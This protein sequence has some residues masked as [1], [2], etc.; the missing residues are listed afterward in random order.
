MPWP[1]RGSST[2]DGTKGIIPGREEFT[3]NIALSKT[4]GD[5]GAI[6]SR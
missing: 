2:L 3:I 4:G 5:A 1:R 6:T